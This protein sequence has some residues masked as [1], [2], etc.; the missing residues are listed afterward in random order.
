M[1]GM[2]TPNG[3][4]IAL[5]SLNLRSTDG[6]TAP[7]YTPGAVLALVTWA[8]RD[9]PHWFGARIPDAPQSIEFVQVGAEGGRNSCRRF[10]AAEL[11]PTTGETTTEAARVNF[12]SGLAP[13]DCRRHAFLAAYGDR[14]FSA[15][16]QRDRIY[17]SRDERASCTARPGSHC[18]SSHR[19]RP[20]ET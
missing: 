18:F 15:R 17:P 2:A 19:G 12:I 13:G 7:S 20:S 11:A 3:K 9:D 1:V 4:D 6:A 16:S 8:Q 5:K 10:A 14:H